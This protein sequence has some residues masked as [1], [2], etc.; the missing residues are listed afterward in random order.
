MTDCGQVACRDE[1]VW[2]IVAERL[3][4]GGE[5]VLVE[6][7]GDLELAADSAGLGEVIH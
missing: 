7:V 2:V 5:G 3:P 1:S 4:A 6:V